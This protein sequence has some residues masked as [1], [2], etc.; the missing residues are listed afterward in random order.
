M[1]AFNSADYTAWQ[2]RWEVLVAL[3]ADLEQEH[4][5]TRYNS[6][7][8]ISVHGTVSKTIFCSLRLDLQNVYV[9]AV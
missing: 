5:F 8:M 9:E 1:I 2:Y 3:Q 4:A 7:I 6:I